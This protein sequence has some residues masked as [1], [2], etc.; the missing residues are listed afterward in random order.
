MNDLP[1]IKDLQIPDGVSVFPVAY[2][3][4]V[5]LS[6]LI[7]GLILFK[8]ISHYL[9]VNKRRYALKEAENITIE[10]PVSAAVL[11][12]EL[13][14]RVCLLKYK[15]ASAFSGEDWISFLNE[16]SSSPLGEKAAKLL[17]FAPFMNTDDMTYSTGDA[18]N[19][20]QFCLKWIGEN[21]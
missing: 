16:H 14:R 21:L 15:E 19:L 4:W 18:E 8:I 3:W 1:E 17:S 6:V 11:L 2:G 10:N 5:V 9:R 20:K 13:L 12:S 7:A